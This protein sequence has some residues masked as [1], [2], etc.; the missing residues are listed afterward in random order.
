MKK[1]IMV[2]DAMSEILYGMPNNNKYWCI[3]VA[4]IAMGCKILMN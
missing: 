2:I 3:K 4:F 1:I